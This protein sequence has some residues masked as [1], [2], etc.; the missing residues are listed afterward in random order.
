MSV[1]KAKPR[2]SIDQHIQALKTSNAPTPLC[3]FKTEKLE[4]GLFLHACQNPGCTKPD[5]ETRSERFYRACNSDEKS[6]H[7]AVAHARWVHA[8][9]PKRSKE[10]F[11]RIIEDYCKKCDQYESRE[12]LLVCRTCSNPEK[13][14]EKVKWATEVCP[15]GKWKGQRKVELYSSD[16]E[17]LF[18][19]V[20]CVN[21][22][23]RPDRWQ[24]FIDGLPK[25]WPWPIPI[26]VSAVDGQRVKPPKWWSQ[27]GPAWG[28]YRTHLNILEDVLNRNVHSVLF[29]EDDAVFRKDFVAKL[30]AKINT[31]PADAG[32]IY[33]GG[34]NLKVNEYP[35]E[36]ITEHWYRPYNINRTHA[37]GLRGRSMMQRVYEH[38]LKQKWPGKQHIDHHYGFLH[39]ERKDPIYIPDEWLVGQAAGKSD[40]NCKDHQET[41]WNH[42]KNVKTV[43]PKNH[44]FIAVLG[45]HSSGSSCIAGV[46][47][48]LGVHMG[49]KFGGYYGKDPDNNC[50]FEA[51]TLAW[52]CEQAL[53]F[54]GTELK[55]DSDWIKGQLQGWINQRRIEAVNRKTV[56]GGK[57]PQLVALWRQLKE[58]CGD[59]LYVV[60]CV[61]PLNDSIASVIRRDKA[62]DEN[63]IEREEHQRYL[64]ACQ[65]QA[66]FEIDHQKVLDVRYYDLTEDPEKV[67]RET[68]LPWLA[69]I[70]PDVCSGDELESKIQKAINYVKPEL[71]HVGK[72]S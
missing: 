19:E 5:T 32:M 64:D 16:L 38:L 46:L 36:K 50:G 37:Y 18:S 27:G 8:G 1:K 61:R 7:F 20:Y 65:T 43:K 70:M 33:L 23:R 24:R 42:A 56:A 62:A 2:L 14:L 60:N 31:L 63:A 55:K 52:L 13:V 3:N 68:I 47:C 48:H 25:D 44:P 57:Y 26:R 51:V 21:L 29:L 4:N 67:I 71:Q 53:P 10:E 59:Q 41:Y 49:N 30:A 39:Q 28:C 58:V 9:K 40:I 34:Q 66:M 11:E 69:K 15:E 12:C 54:P 22:Y 6:N 17:S 35:P 72:E 45:L